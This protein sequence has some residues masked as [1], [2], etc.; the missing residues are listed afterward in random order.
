MI[1]KALYDYYHRSGDLAP[2]GLEYKEIA[3]LIVI[4]EDGNFIRLEDRRKEDSRSS[5]KSLVVKGMRSSNIKPYQFWD[6]VEYVL[7]YTK[8]HPELGEEDQ[9]DEKKVK[10]RHD[11]ISK[12]AAKHC[13]FIEKCR[14]TSGQFP[15]NA[16]FRAVCS[17]YEKGELDQVKDSPLWESITKKPAVNVSF[18]MQGDLQIVAEEEDLYS[19]ATIHEVENLEN[20]GRTVCLIT[21]E[22]GMPVESTTPTAIPG[23]QATGRL[24][25]FQVKSGYDSYGKSKGLNAPI[26]K[27]AEASFTTAL[28]KLLAKDSRNK[29]LIGTRTFIFWASSDTEASKETENGLFNVLGYSNEETDDPN[30]RIE[31]VRKAFQAIYS[32]SLKTNLN[33]KFY[34]LGLA[35]NSARIAVVYWNESELQDFAGRIL[36]HFSDME[37]VDRR[38]HK[39]PYY[40]L[41]QILGAVTMK[42]K[43]ADVQPNLPEAV[44][45]SMV[46]DIPYPYALLLAC[47]QRIR[48]E[49][50]VT[51]TRAAILKA[52]LNRINS[53]FKKIEI[54][55]DKENTNQGYLC[56]RLFATLE[57][58]QERS[59]GITSIRNRYFNAASATPATVFPT[60]LNL[61]VHHAEKLSKGNQIY[62]EQIK[63]EI[64]DKIPASGFPTHLDL[65]D[66]GRFMVGYYH[67]QQE[68]YTKKANGAETNSEEIIN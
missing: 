10:A 21:G 9:L 18:L 20:A 13:A 54:M 40:G 38:I 32:G 26:S 39:K 17:F 23:G 61:S 34:F 42:G 37:I 29:F 1:L 58:V 59:S 48:A 11:A 5:S 4:D 50:H 25:A 57:H 46:Q 6:N 55:I 66:Q 27:E 12:A 16:K 19:L 45:K 14:S 15:D 41:H 3:F 60:L 7:N 35:P 51:I 53:N 68:F 30:R 65:Q 62:Y 31:Q 43:T 2:A 28:N 63:R 24:V 52:Y 36:S 8:D 22:A 64:V 33:D 49:Q 44:I 47:I 56:G 67:Q